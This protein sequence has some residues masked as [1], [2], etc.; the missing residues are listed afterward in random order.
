MNG[1]QM[2]G[3]FVALTVAA[4]FITPFA[5]VVG[6]STGMQSV[7]TETTANIG[8]A[9]DLTGYD[10]VDDSVVVER[11]NETSASNETL[12]EGTD[13]EFD[14]TEASLTPLESGDVQEGDTLYVS[15][16]YRATSD[17]VATVSGLVPLFVVLLILVTISDKM[18]L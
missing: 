4:V 8:Q 2:A 11:Y 14:N 18:D 7:D 17:S 6:S 1:K 3:V 16:D 12:V 5:N 13:Y 15:Y 9:D 10:V